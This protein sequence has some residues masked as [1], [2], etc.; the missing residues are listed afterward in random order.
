M[1]FKITSKGLSNLIL[2]NFQLSFLSIWRSHF[3][4]SHETHWVAWSFR[5]WNS[6]KW[7]SNLFKPFSFIKMEEL[8]SYS[9]QG[10][11]MKWIWIHGDHKCKVKVWEIHFIPSHSTFKKFSN[12]TQFHTRNHTIIKQSIKTI[13]LITFQNL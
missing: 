7:N 2:W 13:Y 12:F 10:F 11:V 6:S 8:I 3:I 5:I 1:G 4:F 9:L